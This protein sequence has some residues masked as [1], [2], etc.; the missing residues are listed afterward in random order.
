MLIISIL[1]AYCPPRHTILYAFIPFICLWVRIDLM[2][3]ILFSKV[4]GEWSR[5]SLI[6]DEVN[7]RL[8]YLQ[9]ITVV[10]VKLV[11]SRLIV[12]NMKG[13]PVFDQSSE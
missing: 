9:Y 12:R 5:P 11:K 7:K 10:Y 8:L 6:Y 4:G 1:V 13:T 2:Q 3:I